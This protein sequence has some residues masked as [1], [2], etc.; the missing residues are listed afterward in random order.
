VALADTVEAH[1]ADRERGGWFMT[2]DDHEKLLAREKPAYD[3]A[4]PSGNSVQL[5]N[6]L[7]LGEMT[8]DDRFRVIA[9]R[10]LAAFSPQLTERPLALSEML[11]AL[12]FWTD[13]PREVVVV[14]PG[15][16]PE[17]GP[18]LEVV[19]KTFLPNK[20]LAG[21][22]EA[23]IDELAKVAPIVEGKRALS[24]KP[25]AYV[26]EKGRCEAPTS[27]PAV[28]AEQLAKVKPLAP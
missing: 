23:Q 12:D 22:A 4:E 5:L 20:V 2:S 26:C 21:G 8:G 14:W 10:A 1:Y 25:T 9:E 18:L 19:R 11:L 17:A 27:D 13:T 28:L 16:A 3:G 15:A 6:T 24:G 7:R